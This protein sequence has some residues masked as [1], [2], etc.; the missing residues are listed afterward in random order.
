MCLRRIGGT[1]RST[2]W[3]RYRSSCAAARVVTRMC[4]QSVSIRSA[5]LTVAG[6]ISSLRFRDI[7]VIRARTPIVTFEHARSGVA[8]DVSIATEDAQDGSSALVGTL[9]AE[10]PQLAP[11]ALVLKVLLMQNGLHEVYHGGLGSFRVYMLLAAWL[12][13]AVRPHDLGECLVG[14]LTTHAQG[15]PAE[16]LVRGLGVEFG[17]LRSADCEDVFRR[18]TVALTREQTLL[19][20]LDANVLGKSR[21]KHQRK[22]TEVVRLNGD[23]RKEKKGDSS[24]IDNCG[25]SSK[26]QKIDRCEFRPSYG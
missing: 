7:E 15:M 9:S 14:F 19:A 5:N 25:T 16:L 4:L 18:A 1:S 6:S 26:K 24:G 17:G 11:L 23:S 8:V 20:M 3:L 12:Q 21:L 22:A 13:A 10:F 2:N